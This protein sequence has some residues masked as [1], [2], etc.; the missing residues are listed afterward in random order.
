MPGSLPAPSVTAQEGVLQEETGWELSGSEPCPA[1][2]PVPEGGTHLQ[3][4]LGR[5]T[6][7]SERVRPEPR[8]IPHTPRGPVPPMSLCPCWRATGRLTHRMGFMIILTAMGG[9]TAP[10]PSTPTRGRSRNEA[11]GKTVYRYVTVT[12]ILCESTIRFLT[13][14][15]YGSIFRQL[16]KCVRIASGGNCQST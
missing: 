2:G 6:A 7:G 10:S 12:W 11:A 1:R 9:L 15:F 13:S 3:A 16:G 4:I 5:G 8:R 14:Y